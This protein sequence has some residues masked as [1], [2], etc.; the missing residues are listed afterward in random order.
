M[1]ENENNL[2]IILFSR[3]RLEFFDLEQKKVFPFNLGGELFRDLEIINKNELETQFSLFIN[4]YK[5]RPVPLLIIL[6]NDIC[7]ELEISDTVDTEIEKK[8]NNFLY[9]LPFEESLHKIYKL[10]KGFHLAAINKEIIE[11]FKLILSKL[12]FYIEALVPSSIVG[13][14]AK[15]IDAPTADFI[16]AKLKEIKNQTMISPETRHPEK[17]VEQKKVM[18]INRVF[19]LLSFFLVL[20]LF[21]LFM[22]YQQ[23]IANKTT[24]NHLT[25][26]YD[27]SSVK[28]I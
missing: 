4:F 23:S 3:N 1:A 18:G 28:Y 21:L 10:T 7:F 20:L 9:Y 14:N 5:I 19:I 25:S 12:G 15:T 17:K 24:A 26:K 13:I 6:A 22:L 2:G 27:F 16:L 8:I 11:V